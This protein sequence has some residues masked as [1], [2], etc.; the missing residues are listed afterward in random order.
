MLKNSDRLLDSLGWADEIVADDFWFR[1]C[2]GY[3][4]VTTAQQTCYSKLHVYVVL[5]LAR[6]TRSR[7]LSSSRYRLKSL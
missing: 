6:S 7:S 3:T 2:D 4:R 5:R 1:T